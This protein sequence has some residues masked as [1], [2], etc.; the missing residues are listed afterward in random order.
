VVSS[1]LRLLYRVIREA[2]PGSGDFV[3][4][5]M[6]Y[7][8][9]LRSGRRRRRDIPDDGEAL[10]MWAGVSVF[11]SAE[12]ASAIMQRFPKIGTSVARLQLP[13]EMVDDGTIWIEKTGAD[14]GHFT[15]RGAPE[16]LLAC[17]QS[18]QP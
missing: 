15:L 12:R 17:V 8:D 1:A 13:P 18:N 2:E 6:E 5:A 11:S 3:S 9:D 10:H 14:P 7:I 4:Q 16:D